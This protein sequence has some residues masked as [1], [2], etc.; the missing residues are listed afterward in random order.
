MKKI[1]LL[2]LLAISALAWPA[3]EKIKS[4]ASSDIPYVWSLYP[5]SITTYVRATWIFKACVEIYVDRDY[6]TSILLGPGPHNTHTETFI[7]D[8][9]KTFP[10]GNV[11]YDITFYLKSA[12]KAGIYVPRSKFT[13]KINFTSRGVKVYPD[14]Q[15][16]ID[17]EWQVG[18]T[19]TFYFKVKGI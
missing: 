6:L 2:I 9:A 14:H 4:P 3:C 17:F 10:C 7:V 15:E 11:P 16:L 8:L 19:K 1:N 13:I 12:V 5:I 18:E